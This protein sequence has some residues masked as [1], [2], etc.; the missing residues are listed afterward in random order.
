[1]RSL[2]LRGNGMVGRTV[3]SR[4]AKLAESWRPSLIHGPVGGDLGGVAREIHGLSKRADRP[5]VAIDCTR[6]APNTPPEILL[7]AARKAGRGTVC[8]HLVESLLPLPLVQLV[9]ALEQGLFQPGTE[10]DARLLVTTGQMAEMPKRL[11]AALP[12]QL[13]IPPVRVRGDDLGPIVA[14]VLAEIPAAVDQYGPPAALEWL[15]GQ[16]W[17]GD[18][19]QMSGL[20]A[21]AAATG[22]PLTPDLLGNIRRRM[23]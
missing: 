20:V 16:D 8:F 6:L 9:G 18:L 14:A 23:G 22:A 3:R 13:A 2:A 7:H 15:R 12:E 11:L 19:E 10:V 4:A 21:A 1:M 17:P 5:Y